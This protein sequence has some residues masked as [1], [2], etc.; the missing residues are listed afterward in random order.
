[1]K[2]DYFFNKVVVFAGVL[3][4]GFVTA[5]A[6]PCKTTTGLTAADKAQ[7]LAHIDEIQNDIKAHGE[8]QAFQHIGEH[9]ERF[10]KGKECIFVIDRQEKWLASVPP[11]QVGKNFYKVAQKLADQFYRTAKNGGGW[12]SGFYWMDAKTHKL[13]CKTAYI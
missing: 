2:L 7:M 8:E 12:I 11:K 5:H 9:T 3:S 6:N 10:T 4:V 13:I 1:M